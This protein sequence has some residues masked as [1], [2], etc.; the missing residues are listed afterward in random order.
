MISKTEFFN[1]LVLVASADGHFDNRELLYL[2]RKAQ[3]LNITDEQFDLMIL[4]AKE[5]QLYVPQS[6]EE[7][8]SL[9]IEMIS[10]AMADKSFGEE[11]YVLCDMLSRA[12]NYK[13]LSCVL[14]NKVNLAHLINLILMASADGCITKSE[15]RILE[16][17]ICK[18]GY[19]PNELDQL[20]EMS[21]K[22]SFFIPEE[23][24]EKEQQLIQ[25]LSLAMADNKFSISEYDL[26]VKI[27]EKIG[28]TKKSLDLLLKLSFNI[29]F[30]SIK[31]N[32]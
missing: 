3:E 27:A 11:E 1:N 2:Y 32:K 16:H 8:E 10:V 13:G 24:D 7:R 9:L 12:M 29:D 17:V 15:V 5:Q 31:E 18:L 26:C 25:L 19:N 23:D 4:K 28:Y 21:K 22:M 20:V 6:R 14:E 30:L